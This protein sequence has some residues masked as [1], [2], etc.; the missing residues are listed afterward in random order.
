MCAGIALLLGMAACTTAPARKNLTN[1]AAAAPGPSVIDRATELFYR[2]KR[3]A[4]SGDLACAQ[5]EFQ[6]ALDTV[7]PDGPVTAGGAE[8]EE[9]SRSLYQSVVRYDAMA[10]T[11]ADPDAA[12]GRGAPDELAGV[13]GQASPDELARARQQIGSDDRGA[14][15]DIPVTVNEAV[16]SM[17]ATF[18]SREDVRRR[19]AE[20]L[21]RSGRYMPLIRSIFQ[22]EGLPGDLAYVAMIESSFKTTAH[23]RA[24][25]HGVWQFITATGRRYGLRSNRILDERSDPVK[26]TEAAARYFRDLY[27]I[28]DDWYLAM[29]AYDSGEG[30]VARAMTRTGSDSYWDLCRAG[31]IPKETRLYVPSV[32]AAALIAKNPSHYGFDI[33]PES[34]LSFETVALK[35]PLS[36]KRISAAAKIPYATLRELNPELKT[37]VTPK[38]LRGYPLRLPPGVAET[39]QARLDALPAARVPSPGRMHRVRKGE[40]LA[41]LARRFGVSVASLAEAND[42]SPRAG[43]APRTI[44]VIPDRE[45]P[46]R[47]AS[48]KHHAKMH[49]S[50]PKRVAQSVSIPAEGITEVASANPAPSPVSGDRSKATPPAP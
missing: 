29:A 26:S 14:T 5:I 31:A 44:L 46:L 25:A 43:L 34:P 22:R 11:S 1:P 49:K 41:R 2:G 18:T 19:F 33:R 36:L 37:D 40:T 9:F 45:L 23:S 42:L 48:K 35:K 7:A 30:R 13:S 21:A 28:F 38:S 16:I 47:H 27:E 3:S 24:R 4:L 6:E 15:F 39:V 17:V 10:Q 12:E 50:K 32:I 8:L 20:G